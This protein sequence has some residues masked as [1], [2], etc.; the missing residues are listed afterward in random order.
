MSVCKRRFLDLVDWE[1]LEREDSKTQRQCKRTLV[2][3]EYIRIYRSI[4]GINP[5]QCNSA[6]ATRKLG[7]C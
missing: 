6:E 7:R 2:D 5:D 1:L 3:I 4:C